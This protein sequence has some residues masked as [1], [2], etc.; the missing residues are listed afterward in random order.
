MLGGTGLT[1]SASV[2]ANLYP[3]TA[4]GLQPRVTVTKRDRLCP[5]PEGTVKKL[6]LALQGVAAT[7]VGGRVLGNVAQT[8]PHG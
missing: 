6:D 8:E 5:G 7:H 3:A 2:S 1:V 4:H